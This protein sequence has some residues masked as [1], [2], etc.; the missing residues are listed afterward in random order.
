MHPEGV[1]NFKSFM[2]KC[3]WNGIKYPSEI[4]HSKR[5]LKSNSTIALIALYIK[6]MEIC[7]VHISKINSDC[8]KQIIL[9]MISN[10]EKEGWHYLHY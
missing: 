8:E 3:N 2:N 1:S 6:E 7:P 4:D 10:E 5:F 9:L